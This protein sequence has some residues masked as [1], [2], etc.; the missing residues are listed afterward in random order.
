MADRTVI[1]KALPLLRSRK[2]S[3]NVASDTREV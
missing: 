3:A 2:Q 1:E